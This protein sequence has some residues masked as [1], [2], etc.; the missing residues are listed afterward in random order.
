MSLHSERHNFTSLPSLAELKRIMEIEHLRIVPQEKQDT[1]YADFTA[2][3]NLMKTFDLSTSYFTTEYT[4]KDLEDKQLLAEV[5]TLGNQFLEKVLTS[6]GHLP[7]FD[8]AYDYLA[9]EDTPQQADLIFVFGAKTT[10]RIEKAVE[11]YHQNLA[12]RMMLSGGNP[13]Y[14]QQ[15]TSE[16]EAYAQLAIKAGVKP[17]AIILEK[18]SITIPDNVGTSLHQL[19]EAHFPLTKIILVNSPYSQ[20]RGYSVF[21]KH[22]TAVNIQRVNCATTHTYARDQWYKHP[23]GIKVI[24]NELVK[25]KLGVILNTI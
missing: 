9:E 16:A 15:A 21:Q 5:N 19:Q 14:G 18:T 8:Q 11:L 6:E 13:I 2:A 10:A 3:I 20:R 23:D 24:F 12:P 25:L 1:H 17:S 22:T 4:E 7:V